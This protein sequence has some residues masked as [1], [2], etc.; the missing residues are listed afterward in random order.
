M[1]IVDRIEDAPPR[2]GRPQFPKPV[3]LPKLIADHLNDLLIGVGDLPRALPLPDI[4]PATAELKMSV[5]R[6]ALDEWCWAAVP[7]GLG[8]AQGT[9]RE[10][11]ETASKLHNRDC[12]PTPPNHKHCNEPHTLPPALAPHHREEG[13]DDDRTFEL[14]RREIDSGRPIAV[15]I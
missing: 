11:C 4:L 13:V 15:L 14:I 12:C 5:P 2:F 8:N 10:Q 9:K 3:G 6:Q 1:T 7:V